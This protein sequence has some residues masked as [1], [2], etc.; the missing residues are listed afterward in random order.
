M[1]K[2]TLGP[3]GLNRCNWSNSAPEFPDYHDSEWGYPVDDDQRLFEK[4]CLESFQSGLSW[5]TILNK[6]DN[7]RSAFAEFDFN[8]VAQFTEDD[9]HRLLHDAGIIRHRGK[10]QA[11]INNAKRAQE[12]VRSEGSI[13][14][15]VWRFEPKPENCLE[16][17]TASTSAESI[18]MSKDLKKREWKFVGPTTVFAFMQAMGLINDHA[19]GCCCRVRA[20]EQRRQFVPPS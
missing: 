11:V 9:V 13:A 1:S 18:A 10:I 12:M 7:F 2:V 16:P 17:Q 4:L 6:R 20:T 8:R 14:A 5:R 19:H 3:D 15:Y